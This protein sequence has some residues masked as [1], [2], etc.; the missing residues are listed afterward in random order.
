MLSVSQGAQ[1]R[2]Q[3]VPALRNVGRLL[4]MTAALTPAACQLANAAAGTDERPH[5]HTELSGLATDQLTIPSGST[6]HLWGT[7]Y[8][9]NR[10]LEQVCCAPRPTR[11]RRRAS[12]ASRRS[13][14]IAIIKVTTISI[15][16]A[17]QPN[18]EEPCS[19]LAS[20]YF[21]LRC[22]EAPS[23][24]H[25][26]AA[27]CLKRKG[28]STALCPCYQRSSVQSN[29][30]PY[31]SGSCRPPSWRSLSGRRKMQ[32]LP[33]VAGSLFTST[34]RNVKLAGK[35][36]PATNLSGTGS[37]RTTAR[38]EGFTHLPRVSRLRAIG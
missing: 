21:L 16:T 30:L 38:L 10:F 22:N 11:R 35:A 18:P 31:P 3:P 9:T 14:H 12:A 5:S 37:V 28:V 7:M 25:S 24:C 29:Q 17:H 4:S 32:G 2:L 6:V 15:T 20:C 1:Q 33:D 19:L 34:Y 26:L 13:A 23:P 36:A 27:A 8:H